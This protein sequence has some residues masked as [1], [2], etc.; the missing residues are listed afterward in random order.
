MPLFTNISVVCQRSVLLVGEI[1][2][3]RETIDLPQVT[4]KLFHILL[5]RVHLTIDGTRIY[6]TL[7]HICTDCID[8]CNSTTVIKDTRLSKC[9]CKTTINVKEQCLYCCSTF[10]SHSRIFN[11]EHHSC[12]QVSVEWAIACSWAVLFTSVD[13]HVLMVFGLFDFISQMRD[14]QQKIKCDWINLTNTVTIVPCMF[15]VMARYYQ[16][17]YI[18]L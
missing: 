12:P 10:H 9:T 15:S 7:W 8:R 16:N 2:E 3:P 1:G 11:K 14:N 18:V 13:K 4:N 17:I 5:Y 6:S